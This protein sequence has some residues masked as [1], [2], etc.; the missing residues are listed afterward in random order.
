MQQHV[1]LE[2][3]DGLFYQPEYVKISHRT[4]DLW[5]IKFHTLTSFLSLCNLDDQR[6]RPFPLY[7]MYLR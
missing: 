6:Q 4:K 7:Q 5:S 2:N 1:I 3:P